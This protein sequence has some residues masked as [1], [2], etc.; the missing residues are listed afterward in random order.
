MVRTF[1]KGICPNVNVIA[2]LEYELTYYD[3]AVHHFNHYTTRTTPAT[4]VRVA[5]YFSVNMWVYVAMCVSVWVFLYK[6]SYNTHLFLI[7]II[8]YNWQTN[9]ERGEPLMWKTSTGDNKRCP[10][11]KGELGLVQLK[12]TPLKWG[13][14]ENTTDRETSCPCPRH[15]ETKRA[16]KRERKRLIENVVQFSLIHPTIYQLTFPASQFS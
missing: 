15:K 16:R 13:L 14:L 11:P 2:R 5:V 1:S 4:F 10:H 12:A 9:L 6:D 8:M 7:P 3:S